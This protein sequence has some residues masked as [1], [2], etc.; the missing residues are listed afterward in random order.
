MTEILRSLPDEW[1]TF[2]WDNSVEHADLQ[3]YG[4]YAAIKE[5]KTNVVYVQD[6]D[7]VLPRESFLRLQE[8]YV[9]GALVTN[10][11]GPFREHYND[12]CLLGFGAIFDQELPF[13]AFSKLGETPEHFERECDVYFTALVGYQ[14]W[15]D[16]PYEDLPWAYGPDRLYRQPEHVAIRAK[17]L[18]HARSLR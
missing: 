15:L 9:P 14:T 8:A 12:S 18:E 10:M 11:P 1:D 13:L 16:L 6:D 7:C 4:R 17:A 3:V 2:I 5:A